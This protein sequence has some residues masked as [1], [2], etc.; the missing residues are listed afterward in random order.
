MKRALVLLTALPLLSFQ[1]LAIELLR[2][3][4][5]ETV[6]ANGAADMPSEW[7]VVYLS[8]DS[9]SNDGSFGLPPGYLGNFTGI[10][11]QD[12]IRWVAAWS[13][14][15]EEFGQLLTDPLI[16]GESYTLSGYLHR[17]VRADLAYSGGYSIGLTLDANSK[18]AAGVLLGQ[19]GPTTS[20]DSW[21]HFTLQ[22]D[23]PANAANLPF[24]VF[25]PFLNSAYTGDE[26]AY[27]GL[28]NLSLQT[29]VAT[30]PEAGSTF[31]LCALSLAGL[32]WI[33]R[34]DR[35]ACRSRPFRS[36]PG[37]GTR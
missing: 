26:T 35:Q 9:Y 6:P 4:S 10:T 12:G 20:G 32:S 27:P 23:A 17:A 29:E 7:D 18:L 34:R 28:D 1:V 13:L 2:N 37:G 15:N 19:I 36:A 30:V 31:A 5:F 24:L 8:P 14:V 11:A 22:F 21:E 16:P 3:P 33:Q 25:Q